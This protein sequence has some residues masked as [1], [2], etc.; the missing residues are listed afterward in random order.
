MFILDLAIVILLFI[1]L[2]QNKQFNF[3]NPTVIYLLIHS[4]FVTFRALQIYIYN[5]V[6]IS[7]SFYKTAV[8]IKEIDKAILLADIGLISFFFGFYFLKR[9]F[10]HRGKYL[11]KIYPQTFEL[12]QKTLNIYNTIIAY[13]TFVQPKKKPPSKTI[14]PSVNNIDVPIDFLKYLDTI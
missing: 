13:I 8:S 5:S 12:H 1:Y 11:L 3:L 6:L 2:I 9:K 10:V 4:F 14:M 7:D